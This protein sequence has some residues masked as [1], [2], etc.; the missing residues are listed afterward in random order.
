MVAAVTVTLP[1]VPFAGRVG[2]AVPE[3]RVLAAVGTIVAVYLVANEVM[4]A[5]F[6]HV[7]DAPQRAH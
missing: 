4:K 1:F 3:G 2:M 5:R 6:R 7:W